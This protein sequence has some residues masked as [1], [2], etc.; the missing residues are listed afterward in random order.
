MDD[1]PEDVAQRV[2]GAGGLAGLER[3]TRTIVAMERL[4]G[5][6]IAELRR[7]PDA[8]WEEIGAAC[9]MTRQGAA[10]RWSDRVHASSFGQAADR[11]QRGR[12]EYPRSAVEWLIPRRARRVLD[13]GAGTGKLTGALVDMGLQVVALEPSKRMRARL[14]AAV[15]KAQVLAGSA[16]RI[17]M[18]DG[19]VDAVVVAGAWHWFD[20]AKAVAQIARVL[21]PGGTLSLVWNTRDETEPWVAELG[22]IMHQ[23]AEQVID[24][25]PQIGAP[26]TDLERIEIRWEQ[27][28]TGKE[29]LDMVASRSYVITLPVGER[30]QLLDDIADFLDD[31]PDMAGRQHITMPYIT[32]CTRARLSCDGSRG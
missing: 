29:L 16:E 7:R 28:M 12:P 27:T 20:P 32:Y 10:R 19:V 13:L 23:H 15:P 21:V 22:R 9:G 30:R 4:R 3:L 24:T 17:P 11:Y 5:E 18:D 14:S 6:V 1:A 26:F 25:S 2:A 8:S 31:H